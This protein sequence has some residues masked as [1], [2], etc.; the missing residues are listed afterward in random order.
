ML[1]NYQENV[2]RAVSN[3]N[4]LLFMSEV[5]VTPTYWKKFQGEVL[6]KLKQL[7]F[8]AF[9]LMLC[10]EIH[11]LNDTFKPVQNLKV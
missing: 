2:K 10:Y 1:P 3:E 9:F 4:T 8:S 11:R 6:T 7:V 5:K